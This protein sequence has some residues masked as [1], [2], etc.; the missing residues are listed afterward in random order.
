MKAAANDSPTVAGPREWPVLLMAGLV[1]LVPYVTCHELFGRLYWFADEFDLI[2]QFDRLGFWHWMWIAFAENFVPLFKLLWGGSVFVFGGSYSAML[3]ILWLTHALNVALLGRLMRGAGLSWAGVLFAQLVFA[4]TPGNIETLG[5]SVQWSAVLAATFML[6]ALDC[7]FRTSDARGPIAWSAAS[8]LSFSRGVLTGFL[9][10]G[11]LLWLH[12][13][14]PGSR[15][16]RLTLAGACIAPSVAVAVIIATIV[17]NGNQ[18]HMAGHWG[19]ALMFGTWYYCVNPFHQLLGFESW[20]PRTT[21]ILGV[22]KVALVAWTLAK[23]RG[24][25]RALLLVLLV[26]DL[27]NA[28]LLGVGRYHTGLLASASSRYQYGSLIAVLP[29]AGFMVSRLWSR[30][31]APEC[32]RRLTLAALFVAIGWSMCREWP[33]DL[34]DFVGPRGTE[35]RRILLSD[36]NP[37]P[38]SVPWFPGFPTQRARDL[39]AKYNL[40]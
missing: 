14:S 29:A 24:R 26:F 4:L 21:V 6:L 17:P 15:A 16:R 36:P 18:S 20:G 25:T 5:W 31:H 8:A 3:T 34:A 40:H 9:A 12:R 33:V 7:A 35:N 1:A 11:A 30:L 28:A 22:L 2:D 27:G 10:A 19:A 39:I 32:V 37:G 23:S 38:Y 13:R